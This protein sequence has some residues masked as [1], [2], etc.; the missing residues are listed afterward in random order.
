MNGKKRGGGPPED[1]KLQLTTTQATLG[2][3][4]NGI[5]LENVP[6]TLRD[7][8]LVCRGLGIRYLWADSLCIIQGDLSDWERESGKM[9]N[10]YQRSFLTICAIQGQSCL[11]GF[12][13]RDPLKQVR[14]P[15]ASKISPSIRGNFSLFP[16]PTPIHERL[17]TEW[18][19][20][21]DD[22][23]SDMAE[24]P[25][26][27]LSSEREREEKKLDFASS[28]YE[29]FDEDI[30]HSAWDSRAWT[31][32]EAVLSPRMLVFGT[33]GTYVLR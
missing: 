10:V 6:Q 19:F 12:L 8:I 18:G 32:Q 27:E 33:H 22:L 7:A 30:D 17:C 4:L 16:A 9:A 23:L 31:F 25:R 26:Q 28:E 14:I 21:M 29:P 2:D 5:K 1:A 24:I 3:L 13:R 11:S 15:F 20:D